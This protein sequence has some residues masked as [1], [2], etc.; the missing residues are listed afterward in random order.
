MSAGHD[1]RD[2]SA[3]AD[4]RQAGRHGAVTARPRIRS[5]AAS[6]MLHDLAAAAI[7]AVIGVAV[8]LLVHSATG[9]SP[10]VSSS[11]RPLPP[12]YPKRAEIHRIQ[13]CVAGHKSRQGWRPS[14]KY[15]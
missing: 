8:V 3:T 7:A 11:A 2:A 13:D 12:A 10:L 6:F 15:R 14:G 1:W 4:A 5:R 9:R